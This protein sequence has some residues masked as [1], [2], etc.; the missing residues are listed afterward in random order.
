MSLCHDIH[1]MGFIFWV[2][3]NKIPPTTV[4]TVPSIVHVSGN[5]FFKKTHYKYVPVM[6]VNQGL[7]GDG[8]GRDG[9]RKRPQNN[10]WGCGK[11]P[12]NVK[13]TLGKSFLLLWNTSFTPCKIVPVGH[14]RPTVVIQLPWSTPR[15]WLIAPVN[16]SPDMHWVNS[17]D[18]GMWHPWEQIM[19]HILFFQK[20]RIKHE[21]LKRVF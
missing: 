3:S 17:V 21:N 19:L 5:V 12:S 14:P 2:V 16:I 9:A 8:C 7:P 15:E 20:S 18:P 13:V 1:E 11:I 4:M 6:P 10:P